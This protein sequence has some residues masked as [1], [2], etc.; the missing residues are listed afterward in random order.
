MRAQ[1]FSWYITSLGIMGGLVGLVGSWVFHA[2][3]SESNSFSAQISRTRVN[4]ESVL[5]IPVCMTYKHRPPGCL[6]QF[7]SRLCSLWLFL[8]CSLSVT[9]KLCSSSI[10]IHSLQPFLAKWRS[11]GCP[12]PRPI[13]GI[14]WHSDTKCTL[15]CDLWLEEY[16]EFLSFFRT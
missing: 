3:K 4:Q 14:T 5:P 2:P 10:Q 1:S 12:V 11:V 16:S 9:S 7:F 15:S 6:L 13:Q 8:I